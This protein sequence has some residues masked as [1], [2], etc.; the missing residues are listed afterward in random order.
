MENKA[1]EILK[2]YKQEHIIEL[3]DKS[4]VI[5]KNK[6]IN[7][8]LNIDFEEIKELYD[9]TFEDLY[10]DLE[11]LQPIVGVN[12]DRLTMEELENYEKIG[13]DII[14]NNKFAVATMAGGQGT[15]LRTSKCKG[16]I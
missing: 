14:K 16:Y 1:K 3:I 8:V 11:E 7:Q 4:D 10:V 6:L 15:R 13:T 9:K 12:P 5:V 2:K